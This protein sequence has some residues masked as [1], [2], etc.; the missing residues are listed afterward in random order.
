MTT[1][2]TAPRTLEA[3]DE[4]VLGRWVGRLAGNTSPRRNHWRTREIYYRAAE[5]L[6]EI[7][8]R[9]ALRWKNIVAAAG[10]RGSRSTFYEV[11]G[12]HARHRMVGDLIAHGSVDAIEIALRYQRHDPVAQL[13]DETKVWSYWP[14]RQQM[15]EKADVPGTTPDRVGEALSHALVLW[16]RRNPA[17]AAATGHCPPASAVEDLT[18]IYRGRLAATR[19]VGRL[20]DVL[21]HAV[22]S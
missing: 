16:A 7:E 9:P 15:I 17:L 6:L 5:V 4:T 21:R 10:E 8:P 2:P 14:L 19:A 12:A 22:P 13:I 1:A 20:T 3:F 11:A 18:T